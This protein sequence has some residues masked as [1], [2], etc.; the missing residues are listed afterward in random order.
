M[1][2]NH[3]PGRAGRSELKELT[4][5][6]LLKA[7]VVFAPDHNAAFLTPVRNLV[8][9]GTPVVVFESRPSLPP[10]PNL[11]YIVSDL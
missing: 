3:E 1:P 6:H 10:G 5:I 11:T 9:S 7:G 4:A 2:L 8:R